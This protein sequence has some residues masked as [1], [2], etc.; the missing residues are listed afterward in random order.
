MRNTTNLGLTVWDAD[1]DL[2]N[3]TQLA[4]NWDAI[5]AAITTLPKGV[6]T[7]ASLPV[8]GL[9]AGRVVMLS[10]AASGFPAWT[11]VRYDGSAWRNAGHIEILAAVPSLSNY[12]GRVVMLSAADSGFSAWDVIRYNGSSWSLIGAWVS[13]NTG[14]GALNIQGVQQA[15][16]AYISNAN[17]GIVLIDRADGTKH[18]IYI[19]GDSIYT[20]IVT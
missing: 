14:A 15:G 4:A 16:D 17:R 11:L 13:V 9:F 7:L 8:T 5:D 12:A 10:A 2:F 20:E 18:R 19:S 3:K 6:E 1:N